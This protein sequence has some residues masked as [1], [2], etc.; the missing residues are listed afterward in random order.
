MRR[1]FCSIVLV[2][3]CVSMAFGEGSPA[4]VVL[5]NVMK[6]I[7]GN[8][9]VFVQEHDY[10]DWEYDPADDPDQFDGI[11]VLAEEWATLPAPKNN[12][13]TPRYGLMNPHEPVEIVTYGDTLEISDWGGDGVYSFRVFDSEGRF[14]TGDSMLNEQH[15][16]TKI[17][18]TPEKQDYYLEFAQARVNYGD[19]DA[20]A[21]DLDAEPEAPSLDPESSPEYCYV[22]LRMSA[23][24]TRRLR[25]EDVRV[26]PEIA[27]DY[28]ASQSEVQE[29]MLRRNIKSLGDLTADDFVNIAVE[30]ARRL[31]RSQD[32]Y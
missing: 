15:T 4:H 6:C 32:I 28:E 21:D 3:M 16:S 29:Y 7:G 27:G 25:P 12:I 22:Y 18:L 13:P 14:I 19:D 20:D 9:A 24:R 23:G 10:S 2:M 8:D 11:T 1:I 30:R 17:K 26:P 5:R 31:S